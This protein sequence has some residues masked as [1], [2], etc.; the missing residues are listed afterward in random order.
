[1]I[2]KSTISLPITLS[3]GLK[4]FEEIKALP[5]FIQL[6]ILDLDNSGSISARAASSLSP[7]IRSGMII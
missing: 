2:V 3:L 4:V 6:V 1:M 7:S 5:D